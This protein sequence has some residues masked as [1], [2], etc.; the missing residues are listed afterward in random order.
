MGASNPLT[1]DEIVGVFYVTAA[2]RLLS[3]NWF[4][5]DQTKLH[6]MAFFEFR[7]SSLFSKW[8]SFF[9]YAFFCWSS[10]SHSF[11]LEYVSEIT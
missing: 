11:V 6:K 9:I 4:R 10:L 2:A 5:R 8:L 3:R 1:D 7:T